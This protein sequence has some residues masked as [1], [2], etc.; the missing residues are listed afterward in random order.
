[1]QNYLLAKTISEFSNYNSSITSDP[2]NPMQRPYPNNC[3]PNLSFNLNTRACEQTFEIL[4]PLK[5]KVSHI[6]N[7]FNEVPQNSAITPFSQDGSSM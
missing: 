1:M 5:E 3:A 7:R 4:L 6:E 2:L